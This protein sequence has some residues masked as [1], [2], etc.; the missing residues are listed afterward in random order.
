MKHFLTAFLLLP[1]ASQ[2]SAD[3]KEDR[4]FF[5]EFENNYT[6][7]QLHIGTSYADAQ[8]STKAYNTG[9]L[10]AQG[11]SSGQHKAFNF[12]LD[13]R[14]SNNL[15]FSLNATNTNTSTKSELT[16]PSLQTS[17]SSSHS[18]VREF[19]IG[20]WNG[21]SGVFVSQKSNKSIGYNVDNI[22]L[23]FNHKFDETFS[24]RGG[25]SKNTKSE[26]KD[27]SAGLSVTYKKFIDD[28]FVKSTINLTNS[29]SNY[30]NDKSHMIDATL[31]KSFAKL[32][33][34]LNTILSKGIS[35]PN[36]SNSFTVDKLYILPTLVIDRELS[37][38]QLS[39]GRTKTTTTDYRSSGNIL[40]LSY[41]RDLGSNLYMKVNFDFQDLDHKQTNSRSPALSQ[42]QSAKGSSM[43]LQ[44]TKQF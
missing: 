32:R 22:S 36:N 30:G 2:V 12:V 23:T 41:A 37:Q 20:Y 14:F 3:F 21:K 29:D 4:P 26:Y 5:W 24:V 1:L 33:I 28:Y 27:N 11:K 40:R 16:L 19:R 9:A 17:T 8:S 6:G 34:G 43:V 10:Y 31:M 39:V 18:E 25:F 44:I 7:T 13:H 38:Y 35:K 15:V 42:T